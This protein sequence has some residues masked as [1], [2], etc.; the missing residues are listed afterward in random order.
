ARG[1]VLDSIAQ[2]RQGTL[3]RDVTPRTGLTPYMV[4]GNYPV[5][6]LFAVILAYAAWRRR[7][8]GAAA[9]EQTHA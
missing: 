8:Q 7:R 3:D 5:I 9:A 6:V 2:F 4:V 1:E